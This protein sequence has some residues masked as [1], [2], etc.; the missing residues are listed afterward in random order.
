MLIQY[1]PHSSV[2]SIH[3]HHELEARIWMEENWDGE[4]QG[5]EP[6]KAISTSGDH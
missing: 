6:T 3:L 1:S 4:E 2:G 5:L